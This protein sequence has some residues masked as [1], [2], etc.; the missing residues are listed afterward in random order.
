VEGYEVDREKEGTL[1]LAKS[2]DEKGLFSK[3]TLIGE[4]ICAP[5][6]FRTG[7]C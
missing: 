4:R 5:R 7:P 2:G 1:S 3:N 6:V